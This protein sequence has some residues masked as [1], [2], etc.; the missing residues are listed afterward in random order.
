MHSERLAST[1]PGPLL[2]LV[3]SSRGSFLT[4]AQKNRGIYFDYEP[5]DANDARQVPVEQGA[6]S[7]SIVSETWLCTHLI[8]LA[9]ECVR[10]EETRGVR[11][12]TE[13]SQGFRHEGATVEHRQEDEAP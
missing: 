1:L 11:L 9:C 6:E 10:R 7:S 5:V 4:A 2:L 13:G 12:G 8:K 3:Q